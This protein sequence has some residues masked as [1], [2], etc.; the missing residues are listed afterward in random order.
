MGR[1]S[2]THGSEE[3]YIQGFV[4]K[5]TIQYNTIKYNIPLSYI[6]I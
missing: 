2:S 3:G 6:T 5:A 4:G 1:E